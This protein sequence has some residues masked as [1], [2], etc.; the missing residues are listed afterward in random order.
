[1]LFMDYPPQVAELLKQRNHIQSSFT[2]NSNVINSK[3]DA[4]SSSSA[5]TANGS[6]SMKDKSTKRK[7]F[8]LNRRDK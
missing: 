1:M 6:P 8:N 7:W 5:P 2:I 4:S 3:E